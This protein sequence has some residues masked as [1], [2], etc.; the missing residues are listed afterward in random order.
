MHGFDIPIYTNIVYPFPLNPPKVPEENPTG[1]YRKNFKLPH[2][3]KGMFAIPLLSS[4]PLPDYVL[5][6]VVNELT[7]P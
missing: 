7:S 1:C 5:P 3:W 2:S 4:N 6:F